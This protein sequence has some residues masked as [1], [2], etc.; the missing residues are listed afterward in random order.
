M[1]Q[2]HEDQTT[3]GLRLEYR[4]PEITDLGSVV[5][6]TNANQGGSVQ[7]SAGYAVSPHN[8]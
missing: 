5:E 7:D 3:V 1:K 2:S 6:V 8:S 4:A